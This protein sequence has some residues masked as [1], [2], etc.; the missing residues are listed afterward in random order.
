M[1]ELKKN[2]YRKKNNRKERIL[3]KLVDFLVMENLAIVFSVQFFS[4]PQNVSILYEYLRAIPKK[5]VNERIGLVVDFVGSVII[6]ESIYLRLLQDK[7]G[8]LSIFEPLNQIDKGIRNFPFVVSV[9]QSSCRCRCKKLT[10]FE[11]YDSNRNLIASS[12]D[13]F[14]MS[15]LSI[16]ITHLD[17]SDKRQLSEI[18]AGFFSSTLARITFYQSFIFP[19]AICSSLLI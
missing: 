15:F 1:F 13:D 11:F 14:L 10:N 12:F 17:A 3:N 18:F 4:R 6:D 2:I 19:T 7:F 16:G 9:S 8:F 5:P